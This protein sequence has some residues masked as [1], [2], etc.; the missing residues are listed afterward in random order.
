MA[1]QL[2]LKDSQPRRLLKKVPISYYVDRM[3]EIFK[4][5]NFDINQ[6]IDI[7]VIWKVMSMIKPKLEHDMFKHKIEAELDDFNELMKWNYNIDILNAVVKINLIDEVFDPYKMR[8]T[9]RNFIRYFITQL[10]KANASIEAFNEIAATD[11]PKFPFLPEEKIVDILIDETS[12]NNGLG[13]SET[14][15][16]V[17]RIPLTKNRAVVVDFNVFYLPENSWSQIDCI[18]KLRNV[19]IGFIL[20]SKEIEYYSK[21]DPSFYEELVREMN[22]AIK[23]WNFIVDGG[24]K[25]SKVR[26]NDNIRM[27]R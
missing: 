27:V 11:K 10:E 25:K 17:K 1:N 21:K 7:M 26:N 13:V 19:G 8:L 22:A 6:E 16:R 5:G 4:S 23:N 18:L 14:L 24:T 3:K 2:I 9:P 15:A 20:E 12:G